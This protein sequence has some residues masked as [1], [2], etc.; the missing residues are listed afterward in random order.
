MKTTLTVSHLTPQARRMLPLVQWAMDGCDAALTIVSPN[1]VATGTRAL[2]IGAA[3]RIYERLTA[4]GFSVGRSDIGDQ[5]TDK[6]GLF[7]WLD[8]APEPCAVTSRPIDEAFTKPDRSSDCEYEGGRRH[9]HVHAPRAGRHR[10]QPAAGRSER[11][12]A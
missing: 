1:A 12:P 11:C 7:I 4:M 3:I 2:A 9:V 5:H 8:T 10:V 6:A